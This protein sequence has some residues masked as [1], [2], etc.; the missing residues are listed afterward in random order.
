MNKSRD[1]FEKL[2]EMMQDVRIGAPSRHSI[3]PIMKMIAECAQSG[4]CSTKEICKRVGGKIRFYCNHQGRLNGINFSQ[5]KL[6]G[7]VRWSKMPSTVI[8]LDLRINQ[9]SGIVDLEELRTSSLRTLHIEQNP[10]ILDLSCFER[11]LDPLPLTT[12]Y[13]SRN[14][15]SNYLGLQS[16]L[17]TWYQSMEIISEWTQRSTLNMLCVKSSY[18]AQG[19]NK[20]FWQSVTHSF[21]KNGTWTGP[22]RGHKSERLQ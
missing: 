3:A 10:L 8:R 16:P 5:S 7:T 4:W 13:V 22:T 20:P 1:V 12:F 2:L 15:I 14:Q 17:I 6:S 19:H 9:L 21:F 18:R 11:I